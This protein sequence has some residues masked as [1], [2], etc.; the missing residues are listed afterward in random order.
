MSTLLAFNLTSDFIASTTGADITTGVVTSASSA[1]GS[2]TRGNNSYASDP[3]GSAGPATGATNASLA[4]TAESYLF[5]TINPLLGK[6]MSLT[7]FQI[8]LTR[9]GASTPRGYDI[10]SSVDDYAVT[11][12]TADLATSRTDHTWTNVDIDLSD[13]AFQNQV[14]PIT[15]RVYIYAPSTVNVVDW[16]DLTILGTTA[17][18]GTVEQEGFRFR[19]DDGNET[20]ATWLAAQDTDITQPKSTNTRIRVLLNGTLDR[21]SEDYRLEFR[22]VG[23]TTWTPIA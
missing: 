7:N 9:G 4:I 17:D 19:N 14:S 18:S 10:R 21:G 22:E 1:L 20:N 13:A 11:L 2:F 15:F 3:V 6:Q 12:G 8:K 16:D 5:V 23:G